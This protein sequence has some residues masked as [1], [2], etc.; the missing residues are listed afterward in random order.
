MCSYGCRLHLWEDMENLASFWWFSVRASW[1]PWHVQGLPQGCFTSLE[2]AHQ[3]GEKKV[4]R[5]SVS[6]LFYFIHRRNH[7]QVLCIVIVI[8][9]FTL[10]LRTKQGCFS[11]EMVSKECMFLITAIRLEAWQKALENVQTCTFWYQANMS[12]NESGAWPE[13][14]IVFCGKD[15]NCLCRCNRDVFKQ[16]LFPLP[17]WHVTVGWRDPKRKDAAGSFLEIFSC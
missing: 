3:E 16:P 4:K 14:L 11:Y 1:K 6:W 7:S 12:L 17:L 8:N 15:N 13:G 2:A 9:L 5:L 10:F